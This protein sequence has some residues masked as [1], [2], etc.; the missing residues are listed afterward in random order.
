MNSLIILH[1]LKVVTIIRCSHKHSSYYIKFQI[2]GTVLTN[3]S[4]ND[5]LATGT[6]E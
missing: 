5:N 2:Q 3:H 4:L 1:C 6:I